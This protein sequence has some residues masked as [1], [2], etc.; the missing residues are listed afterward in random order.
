VNEKVG[1]F[2]FMSRL[3]G[4][5]HVYFTDTL[6]GVQRMVRMIT[7]PSFSTQYYGGGGGGG[8]GGGWW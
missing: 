2:S 8:G 7:V 6:I 5:T 3:T 4:Q 1:L